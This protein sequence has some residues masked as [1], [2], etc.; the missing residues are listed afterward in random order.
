MQGWFCMDIGVV[1]GGKLGGFPPGGGAFGAVVGAVG[2]DD[3]AFP[4]VF[5]VGGGGAGDLLEED[6]EEVCVGRE[7]LLDAFVLVGGTGAGCFPLD[8][9]GVGT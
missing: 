4:L 2:V 7:E 8:T 3:D 1:V 6:T 5:P 9:G